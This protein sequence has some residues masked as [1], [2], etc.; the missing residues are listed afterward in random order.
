MPIS[1]YD[2][3]IPVFIRGL[4]QLTAILNKAEDWAKSQGIDPE[5]LLEKRLHH[6]MKPLP[7]QVQIAS[8]TSKGF[9][10]R[11]NVSGI[12]NPNYTDT[13]SSFDELYRRIEQTLEFLQKFKPEDFEGAEDK[14]AELPL[15]GSVVKFKGIDYLTKF[16]L[17]NFFFHVTAAYGILR[18][19]G[20]PVGKADF[21]G[22]E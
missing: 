6:D 17:P 9:A 14:T 13:E 5:S 12:E 21:L 22:S 2:I 16:A 20:V 3:S 11:T 10:A 15:G 7:F 19:Q 18:N 8:N 4:K 1:L